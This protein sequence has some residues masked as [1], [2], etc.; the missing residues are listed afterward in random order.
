MVETK[1]WIFIFPLIT[2]VLMVISF[3]LPIMFLSIFYPGLID[4]AIEGPVLPFGRGI[5]EKLE[6]YTSLV[7]ETSDIQTAFLWVGIGFAIFYGLDILFLV[8]SAIRVKT[9]NKELKKARR[10][11][12]REGIA[13]IIAQVIVFIVMSSIVPDA[14]TDIDPLLEL[15]FTIG[16]GMI[17]INVGGGILIFAYILAK[18]AGKPS[19]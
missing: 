11:W 17:L 19:V 6:P 9:G 15:G 7:P 14:I 4:P 10:K 13:M 3:F 12:L 18:I 1:D 16:L 5:I 2:A 8:I